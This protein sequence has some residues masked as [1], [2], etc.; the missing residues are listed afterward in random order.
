VIRPQSSLATL[1]AESSRSITHRTGEENYNF[2]IKKY[3]FDTSKD[4]NMLQNLTTWDLRLYFTYEE[5]KA[6]DLIALKIP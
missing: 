2:Y 5:R 4:F 3:I 6:A 1:P